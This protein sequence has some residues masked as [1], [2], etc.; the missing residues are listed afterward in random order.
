M[1]AEIVNQLGGAFEADIRKCM[2]N[3]IDVKWL[4]LKEKSLLKIMELLTSIGYVEYL[5]LNLSGSLLYEDNIEVL[6]D[7]IK[8]E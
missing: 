5:R 4:N 6:A 8:N 1:L 7:G 2:I 3:N